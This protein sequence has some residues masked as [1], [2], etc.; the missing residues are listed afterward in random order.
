MFLKNDISYGQEDLGKNEEEKEE[1]KSKL[2]IFSIKELFKVENLIIR[3]ES[4]W[5]PFFDA[6]VLLVTAYSCFTT[7]WLVSFQLTSE[8]FMKTID[9]IVTL[10]FAFD[11]IFNC[12]TEFQDR[13][14]F[15]RVANIK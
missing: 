5:K 11:L 3:L 8:G 2:Q 15:Q 9:D 12:M 6:T 13:E 1:Q 14:T 4:P 10:I 7:V